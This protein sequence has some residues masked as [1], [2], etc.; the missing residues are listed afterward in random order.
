MGQ[1]P[2]QEPESK[3]AASRVTHGTLAEPVFTSLL[4]DWGRHG[5]NGIISGVAVPGCAPG[6]GWPLGSTP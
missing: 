3:T 2:A 4:A 1:D 5:G 6:I